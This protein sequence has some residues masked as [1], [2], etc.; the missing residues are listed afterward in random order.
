MQYLK[1][2]NNVREYY[3]ENNLSLPS[4]TEFMENMLKIKSKGIFLEERNV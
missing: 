1:A 4:F 3:I 2:Y